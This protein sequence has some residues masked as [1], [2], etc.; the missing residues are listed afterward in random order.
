MLSCCEA[1][2]I[3]E[4]NDVSNVVKFAGKP[5]FVKLEQTMNRYF[6]S[7]CFLFKSL[8]LGIFQS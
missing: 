3:T 2:K 6:V 5:V 8:I 4:S 7:W 1:R